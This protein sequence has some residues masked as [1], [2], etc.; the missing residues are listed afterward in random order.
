MARR[1]FHLRVWKLDFIFQMARR[2]CQGE[3]LKTLPLVPNSYMLLFI[4]MPRVYPLEIKKLWKIV[5]TMWG[6]LSGDEI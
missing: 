5:A 2:K 1:K 4:T 6:L 3:G